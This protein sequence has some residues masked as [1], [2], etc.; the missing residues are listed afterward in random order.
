MPVITYKSSMTA[1]Q[2]ILILKY[3]LGLI[4]SKEAK[5]YNK[6]IGSAGKLPLY[7]KQ[8]N[9]IRI[10]VQLEKDVLRSNKRFKITSL[11]KNLQKKFKYKIFKDPYS[12][13][14][15]NSYYQN[16]VFS[17]ELVQELVLAILPMVKHKQLNS[18]VES[19]TKGTMIYGIALRKNGIDFTSLDDKL[20]NLSNPWLKLMFN[21]LKQFINNLDSFITSVRSFDNEFI[22]TRACHDLN[23]RYGFLPEFNSFISL[24]P[25][26]L[27]GTFDQP[28]DAIQFAKNMNLEDLIHKGAV[29]DV[30]GYC[31]TKAKRKI[32]IRLSGAALEGKNKRVDGFVFVAEDLTPI[33]KYARQRVNAI[34]PVLNKISLGDFSQ[35]IEIPEGNDEFSELVVAIDLMVDNLRE[36]IEENRSKTEQVQLSHKKLLRAKSETDAERVKIEAFLSHIGDAIVAISKE[37]K[38]LFIN[39]EAERLFNKKSTQ[40]IGEE[41]MK[42]YAL[43]DENGNAIKPNTFPISDAIKKKKSVHTT[44]YFVKGKVRVPLATSVSPILLHNKMLGIVGTFRDITKEKEI[45]QAKSEFVSLASH[46]MRTPLTG[47]KWLIQAALMEGK[48]TGRQEEFLKDAD[49]S[50]ERMISLVNDLL[51]ISRLEAGV[52]GVVAD[53]IELGSFIEQLVKESR[54]VAKEKKQKILYKKPAKKINVTFDKHLIS[55]VIVS[56]LSNAMRYSDKKKTIAVSITSRKKNFEIQVTDQGIGISSKDQKKIFTRFFRSEE[57]AK[58]DTTGSG[59]GLYIVGKVLSVCG[60]S[61]ECISKPSKGTTFVVVLPNKGVSRTGT[62]SLVG[63]I[64]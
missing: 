29:H 16:V 64:S 9:L 57:A 6:Q 14:L 28:L 60:G 48:L 53:K 59:L 44:T 22:L 27:Q 13:V 11:K 37:G 46:Q 63:R 33:K 30:E 8:I 49:T 55:E 40:V 1:K 12:L 32:P 23:T 52:V 5:L 24:L 2:F 20:H 38:I 51:N 15:A 3:L 50:N 17:Q 10:Y 54:Y 21:N 61:I 47:V 39:P 19:S 34:T 31:L 43:E 35:N 42:V 36:L 18:L 26:S 62:K 58:I 25:Q 4:S 41:Y 56:L 45:D 7:E